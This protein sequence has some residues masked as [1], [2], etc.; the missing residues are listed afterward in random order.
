MKGYWELKK[1]ALDR[2]L[3]WTCFGR[4]RG[5]VGDTL[6]MMKYFTKFS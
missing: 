5:P 4:G 6:R 2:P 1:E 3:W